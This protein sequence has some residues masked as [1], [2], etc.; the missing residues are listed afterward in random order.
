MSWERGGVEDFM[1]GFSGEVGF[2]DGLQGDAGDNFFTKRDENDLA[3][4]ERGI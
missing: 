1:D 4:E 2:R 3:G